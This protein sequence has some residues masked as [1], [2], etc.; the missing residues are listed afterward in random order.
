MPVQALEAQ[1]RGYVFEKINRP[2]LLSN[3][4]WFN[5]LAMP[6]NINK[7]GQKQYFKLYHSFVTYISQSIHCKNYNHTGTVNGM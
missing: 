6:S 5:D 3:G 7:L 1:G 4:A 2:F